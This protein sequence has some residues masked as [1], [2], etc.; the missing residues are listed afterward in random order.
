MDFVSGLVGDT[1]TGQSGGHAWV[2]R[3]GCHGNRILP[4]TVRRCEGRAAASG[5]TRVSSCPAAARTPLNTDR[6]FARRCLIGSRP[7]K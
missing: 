3:A 1:C 2:R 6:Q 7:L 4:S 5:V